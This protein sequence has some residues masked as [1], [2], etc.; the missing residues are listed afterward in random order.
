MPSL[1]TS[2]IAQGQAYSKQ[3]MNFFGLILILASCL[4]ER[5]H[6]ITECENN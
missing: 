2:F 1:Y 5:F 3:L 4:M 6:E